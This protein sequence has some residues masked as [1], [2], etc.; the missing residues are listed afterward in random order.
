M[1]LSLIFISCVDVLLARTECAPTTILLRPRLRETNG[2]I[3]RTAHDNY[4]HG[5]LFLFSCTLLVRIVFVL[6]TDLSVCICWSERVRK[7]FSSV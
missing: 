3:G 1:K 4:N 7:S 5:T 2:L 6:M